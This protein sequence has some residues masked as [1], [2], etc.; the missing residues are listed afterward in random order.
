MADVKVTLPRDDYNPNQRTD[1]DVEV[2]NPDGSTSTRTVKGAVQ[3]TTEEDGTVT[4]GI[5]ASAH[6]PFTGTSYED[7]VLADSPEV[8]YRLGDSSGLW[9]DSS[10]NARHTTD[11]FDAGGA[12]P[13]I[14]HST[15]LITST[16]DDG[17]VEF[18]RSEGQYI[19]TDDASWMDMSTITMECWAET[20]YTSDS[21]GLFG[22]WRSASVAAYG[23]DI[24]ADGTFRFYVWRDSSGYA[25]VAYDCDANDGG[26]H[27]FVGTYDGTTLRLYFDGTEVNTASY[28]GTIRSITEPLIIGAR[29]VEL[30]GA[31]N[32]SFEGKIDEVA[33]YSGA[34]SATRV[35]AHY[36]AGT[37]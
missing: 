36:N 24:K 7:A 37:A 29:A 32:N 35:L 25:E 9:Q 14:R 26:T 20:S 12:V 1:I 6:V 23:M 30:S 17:C 22:R 31:G 3:S 27:H 11:H 8:Y 15:G 34:L 19:Q 21:Q 16:D 18:E 28:S 4:F 13:V 5:M 10:G 33:L 2:V